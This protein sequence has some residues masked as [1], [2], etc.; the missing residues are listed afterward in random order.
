M[1][2]IALLGDIHF[3][4]YARS[5]EFSTPGTKMQDN[6]AGAQSIKNGIIEILKPEKIDYIFVAGDITSTGSPIEYRDCE[7]LI[8]EVAREVGV[9]DSNII[10]SL[11]NHDVDWRIANLNH[12]ENNDENEKTYIIKT[13][14]TYQIV[15][16]SIAKLMF[17]SNRFRC[18]GPVPFSGIF[19]DEQLV[20]FVLNSGYFCSPDDKIPHGKIDE[21]QLKWLE[22][23]AVKLKNIEKWKILLLHHH[24]FNYPYHTPHHDVSLLR[25]GSEVIEIA[26]KA[27]I[28]VI[29]HGHRHHPKAVNDFR[30][31]WLNPITFIC[32]GSCSVNS[33]HRGNG[34]IPNCFHL[35]ELIADNRIVKLRSYEFSSSEGWRPIVKNCPE[36][37]IDKE[38]IFLRPY[39]DIERKEKV[40]ELLR[41]PH[42]QH[43]E[44]PSWSDLPIE[45]KTLRYEEL[46]AILNKF[47]EDKY[48]VYGKYPENVALIRKSR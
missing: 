41:K 47:C 37:P 2:K 27:G 8:T 10:V 42:I 19:E 12:A 39:T 3:G 5:I 23:E 31:E 44:L 29:C 26:G 32:S 43:I 20:I 7:N 30:D 38:M 1:I 40:I 17:K 45:L 22:I 15:A 48:I 46:N 21:E 13:K 16:A 28:H 24:L 36:T 35:L 11:G 18:H 14:E 4:K 34:E 25:E 9:N 6:T 33:K